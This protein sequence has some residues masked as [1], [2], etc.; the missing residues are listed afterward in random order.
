MHAHH[1]LPLQKMLG[2]EGALKIIWLQLPVMGRDTF[3]MTVYG[4]KDKTSLLKSSATYL[5][6]WVIK[7][8]ILL[9]VTH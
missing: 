2:S 1:C 5:L 8:K 3:H 9:V 7:S 6:L 4:Q